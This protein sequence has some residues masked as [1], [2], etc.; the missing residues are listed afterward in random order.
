MSFFS[1]ML[2]IAF[3]I[4]FKRKEKYEMSPNRKHCDRLWFK[5]SITITTVRK[6]RACCILILY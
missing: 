1:F 2:A 5:Y 4:N 6:D 3:A